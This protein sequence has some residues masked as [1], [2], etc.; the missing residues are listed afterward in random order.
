MDSLKYKT[1]LQTLIDAVESLPSSIH[2]QYKERLDRINHQDPDHRNF[3]LRILGWLTHAVRP[4]KVQELRHALAVRQG[5]KAI[6]TRDLDMEDLFV[7]CCH[8]LVAIEQETQIIR[9]IHHTA[10]QYLDD[11]RLPMF[12][13]IQAQI[14]G[15]CLTYLSFSEFERG[16]CTFQSFDNVWEVN[17]VANGKRIAK[18]RFLPD[19]LSKFP[20]LHYAASSWG[21]HATG[22]VGLSHEKKIL[23]FLQSPML[24]ESAAQV[25]DSDLLYTWPLSEENTKSIRTH[26]PLIVSGSFGLGRIMSILLDK[27]EGFDVNVTYGSKKS[28]LLHKAV[29]AGSLA[30]TRVLLDAGADIKLPEPDSIISGKRSILYKA[31][32]HGHDAIVEA[33]LSQGSDVQVEESAIYCA[34]FCESETAI[35]FIVNRS[36]DG[37]ERA[38]RL[39][40]ILLHAASLGKVSVIDLA[41]RLGAN[42]SAKDTNGQTALFVAV[43]HGR[44]DAVDVLLKAGS[45][46]TERDASSK[47][48]L[49]VAI[50]THQIIQERLRYIWAYGCT[51]ER[52]PELSNGPCSLLEPIAPEARFMEDLDIWLEDCTAKELY[53][54]REFR[55]DVVYEDSL[56]IQVMEKI[57][58][59]GG[60]V[61]EKNSEGQSI[62]HLA[63][64]ST[65]KRARRF[66]KFSIKFS[67]SKLVMDPTDNNGRTPLHYAA[68]RGKT[69]IMDLLLSH[70][71]GIDLVDQKKATT[72]H[73]SVLSPGCTRHTIKR[74]RDLIHNQDD[75]CRT[76]LH[77]AA[78]VEEPNMKVR[79]ILLGAGVRPD[80]VDLRGRTAQYYYDAHEDISSE[81]H[82]DQ[83]FEFPEDE[84]FESHEDE[85]SGFPGGGGFES[86]EDENSESPEDENSESPEDENFQSHEQSSFLY[87]MMCQ[88]SY[89]LNDG[90]LYS[91]IDN[92]NYYGQRYGVHFFRQIKE[93]RSALAD[94]EKAW[95]V[96]S[97]SDDEDFVP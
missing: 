64:C 35:Q 68:A 1:S 72:L 38:E 16:R 54:S 43:E 26:L 23:T 49:Q 15:T 18:R 4:M 60:D 8:G 46:T 71:A 47:S 12:S 91:A 2:Q 63:A 61:N 13:E 55:R 96:V 80:T 21:W 28:T 24:L 78:L 62:L 57:L 30:L 22:D 29:E 39:H 14:L 75:L 19:R 52:I 53:E 84:S 51:Y 58:G 42:V 77:Y 31:I 85:S 67:K 44:S 56:H 34:T 6:A 59:C 88:C 11:D 79:D 27:L 65:L 69:D 7:P 82:K 33:L 83:G 36:S 89:E 20:F 40:Q 50:G 92:S 90:A 3:A 70:G 94:K 48:L 87:T 95:T 76:A 10:Q 45:S 25:Q 37:A 93:N 81:S 5:N 74:C 9:L 66:I 32:A 41:L 73:F 86:H 17:E 97:N